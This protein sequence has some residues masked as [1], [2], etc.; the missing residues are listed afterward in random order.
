MKTLFPAAVL[1]LAMVASH[2]ASAATVT[3]TA[4][5]DATL[6]EDPAGAQS[7]GAS[8]FVMTGRVGTNDSSPLRRALVQ[9][10]LSALPAGAVI[11]AAELTMTATRVKDNT[12][13][14]TTLQRVTAGWTEGTTNAGS[15]GNGAP[16]D[17]GDATWLHRSSPS[18]W[19]NA[20]GDFSA[21]ISASQTIGALGSYT[22]SS[23]GVVSDVQFWA[24]NPSQNF[25]WMVRGNEQ[26]PQSVK[27]FSS[28]EGAAAPSLLI[29]YTQVPEPGSAALA[30]AALA[31]ALVRR[32][33]TAQ[34][35]R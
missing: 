8:L 33:K 20:G 13:F 32:R 25:G 12:A 9:F 30:A 22:W 28:H 10:D 11:T 24:D 4:N 6:Y 16:A 31:P 7:S 19:A 35:K 5:R 17:A 15:G 18:L 23:S 2:V 21:T 34:A 27:E 1:C 29:T 26:T 3:I 14:V